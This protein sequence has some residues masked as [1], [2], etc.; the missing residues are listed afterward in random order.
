MYMDMEY[1]MVEISLIFI[2]LLII[3]VCI[4]A[5]DDD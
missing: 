4:K 2:A 1:L 3:I 5:G